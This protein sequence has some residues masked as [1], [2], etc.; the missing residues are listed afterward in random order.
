[1]S[2]FARLPTPS[3]SKNSGL[4]QAKRSSGRFTHSKSAFR[5]IMRVLG[6][7]LADNMRTRTMMR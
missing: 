1:M 5:L 6:K 7:Q 4:S 3:R 2:V